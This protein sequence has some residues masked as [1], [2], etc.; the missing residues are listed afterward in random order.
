MAGS[1]PKAKPRARARRKKSSAAP[2]DPNR[3]GM[4]APESITG[5]EE[6]HTGKRTIRIIHTTERDEYDP[7]P[8][9]SSNKR[10]D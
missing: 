6:F 2:L 3:V 9:S 4:P 8:P 5:V 1:K 10:T 7:D